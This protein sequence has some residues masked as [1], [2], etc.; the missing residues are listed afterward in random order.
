MISTRCPCVCLCVR[1]W[2]VLTFNWAERCCS[3]AECSWMAS[4]ESGWWSDD[5]VVGAD[6]QPCQVLQI[7]CGHLWLWDSDP[8]RPCYS[9]STPVVTVTL[10]I[11]T[12]GTTTSQPQLAHLITACLL[13]VQFAFRAASYI[14]T[15]KRKISHQT[16]PTLIKPSGHHMYLTRDESQTVMKHGLH[17]ADSSWM[18]IKW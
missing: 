8:A 17:R 10:F 16:I 1:V 12:E 5:G 7:Y 4:F 11:D 6:E 15:L 18:I 9:H 3:L 2:S 14:K 13:Q